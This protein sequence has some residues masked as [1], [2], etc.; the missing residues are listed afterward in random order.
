MVIGQNIPVRSNDN[1]GPCPHLIRS[2]S[3]FSLSDENTDNRRPD[4]IDN[5]DNSAGIA[6]QEKG[7]IYNVPDP[8]L[9]TSG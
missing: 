5:I 6:V 3:G 9:K 8:W 7:I 1:P 4:A 2:A